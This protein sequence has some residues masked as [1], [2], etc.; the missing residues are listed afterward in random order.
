MERRRHHRAVTALLD[1]ASRLVEGPWSEHPLTPGDDGLDETLVLA[2]EIVRRQASLAGVYALSADERR[3][4]ALGSVA[5]AGLFEV[6][7]A[8]A[9]GAVGLIVEAL[10]TGDELAI[11]VAVDRVRA[12]FSS[13]E[14]QTAVVALI[15]GWSIELTRLLGVP[16]DE[17]HAALADSI[18]PR[19]VSRSGVCR[20][21][22]AVRCRIPVSRC[23]RRPVATDRRDT[24][25]RRRHGNPTRAVTSMVLAELPRRSAGE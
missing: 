5:R 16:I 3:A 12:G 10:V 7:P 1:A 20:T 13:D 24:V 8:S 11:A 4:I 9:I 15:A 17:L 19:P 25:R 14:L 23:Q 21:A 18:H 22:G 6:S 2:G